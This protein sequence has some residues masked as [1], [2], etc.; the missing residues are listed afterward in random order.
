MN[1]NFKFH[2]VG[3]RTYSKKAVDDGFNRNCFL[4]VKNERIFYVT[5]FSVVVEGRNDEVK[6]TKRAFIRRTFEIMEM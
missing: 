5:Q 6:R 3:N 1:F 4:Y 2:E